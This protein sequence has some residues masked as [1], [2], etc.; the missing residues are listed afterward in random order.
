MKKKK[1]KE[2]SS[3]MLYIICDVTKTETFEETY[4]SFY[5]IVST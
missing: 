1:E 3:K 4:F 2:V 5:F